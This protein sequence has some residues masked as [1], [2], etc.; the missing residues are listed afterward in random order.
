MGDFNT[1]SPEKLLGGKR[2]KRRRMKRKWLYINI[3]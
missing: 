3:Y 1:T 2:T